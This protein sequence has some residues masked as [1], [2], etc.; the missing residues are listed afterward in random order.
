MIKMGVAHRRAAGRRPCTSSR[1]RV[2]NGDHA[3][4]IE[5]LIQE[6]CR[7]VILCD[8]QDFAQVLQGSKIFS[9]IDLVRAYHQIPVLE[10]DIPK[11][12]ITMP[13]GMFE[14]PYMSFGLRNAYGTD[15]SKIY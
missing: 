1:R 7:T 8:I 12:A 9:T 5:C 3:A 6:L 2:R 11:T 15:I 14:F 4:T 13:F 10:E